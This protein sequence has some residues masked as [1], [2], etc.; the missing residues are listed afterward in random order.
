MKNVACDLMGVIFEESHI[1]SNILIPKF[2]LKIDK[3]YIKSQYNL[4]NVNKIQEQDFWINIGIKN[5]REGM[6]SFLDEMK[7]NQE[8]ILQIQNLNKLYSF[9]ILSNLP[10]EWK[11][12]LEKKFNLTKLF[13]PRIYSGDIGC[14]KPQKEIYLEYINSTRNRYSEILFIDDKIENLITAKNFRMKTIWYKRED[15]N[16]EFIPDMIIKEAKD[17]ADIL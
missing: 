1:I 6:K 14:E 11:N 7:L 5:T 4:L 9:G 17:L 2:N 10:I 12:Y 15:N 8:F 3:T 16:N 13:C